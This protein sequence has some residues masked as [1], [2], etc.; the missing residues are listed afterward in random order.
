MSSFRVPLALTRTLPA[1]I[2]ASFAE[3]EL[4]KRALGFGILEEI[5]FVLGAAPWF[6]PVYYTKLLIGHA[7]GSVWHLRV[8]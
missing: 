1:A 5:G 8:L 6:A 4:Q 3:E 7:A 2:G